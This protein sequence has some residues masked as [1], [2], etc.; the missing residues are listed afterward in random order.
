MCRS[1]TTF[2]LTLFSVVI[3]LGLV[4]AV[5]ELIPAVDCVQGQG[6]NEVLVPVQIAVA[7]ARLCTSCISRFRP[8][9]F[10]SSAPTVAPPL[11]GR[12]SDWNSAE[13]VLADPE[14]LVGGE[15]LGVRG[16]TLVYI[17]WQWRNF[18]KSYLCQLFFRHVVGQALQN[19]SYSDITFFVR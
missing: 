5:L 18:F 14:R 9:C 2:A 12:K 16:G 19:V 11:H 7:R 15:Y 6:P 1:K 10:H 8:R 13:H 17:G 4:H 3:G